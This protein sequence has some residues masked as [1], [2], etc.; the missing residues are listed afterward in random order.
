MMIL[1][2]IRTMMA[3]TKREVDVRK[4]EDGGREWG[5]GRGSGANVEGLGC[6][7]I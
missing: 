3:K 5:T 2:V 4:W 7:V 6:H 1:S